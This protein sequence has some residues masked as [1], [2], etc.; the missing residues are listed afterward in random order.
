MVEGDTGN[1]KDD[2][3]SREIPNWDCEGKLTA[4]R[5]PARELI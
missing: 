4:G 3:I 2:E 1:G 5:G